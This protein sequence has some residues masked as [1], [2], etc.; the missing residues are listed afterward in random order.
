MSVKHSKRSANKMLKWGSIDSGDKMTSNRRSNKENCIITS[1]VNEC[2]KPKNTFFIHKIHV[3]S[4]CNSEITK[5][6]MISYYNL[7]VHN[8]VTF[9]SHMPI[10]HSLLS[11]MNKT[12]KF[13]KYKANFQSTLKKYC[14]LCRLIYKITKLTKYQGTYQVTFL[15]RIGIRISHSVEILFV[16]YIDK[17]K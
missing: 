17:N 2:I 9:L 10:L 14:I 8:F 6:L 12:I 7:S 4:T 13:L 3:M 5:T 1:C 15:W 11:M 16:T